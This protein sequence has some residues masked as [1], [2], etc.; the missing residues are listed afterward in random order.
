MENHYLFL[1]NQVFLCE[2]C[3]FTKGLIGTLD[4]GHYTGG[5]YGSS[6]CFEGVQ[7]R[8]VACSYPPDMTI[9]EWQKLIL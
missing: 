3:E 1:V 8:A 4:D 5:D 2:N 6:A 7:G 9:L